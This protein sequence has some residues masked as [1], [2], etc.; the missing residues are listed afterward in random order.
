[1]LEVSTFHFAFVVI[2]GGAAF[3]HRQHDGNRRVSMP[4]FVKLIV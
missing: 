3:A 1:M 4:L 2:G